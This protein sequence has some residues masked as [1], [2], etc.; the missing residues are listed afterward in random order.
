MAGGVLLPKL[1]YAIFLSLIFLP[2]VDEKILTRGL[3]L[4]CSMLQQDLKWLGCEF[5][6]H[7]GTI[8][9]DSTDI[10][11]SLACASKTHFQHDLRCMIRA[12]LLQDLAGK[13]PRWSGVEQADV[14]KTTA[15]VRKMEPTQFGRTAL[16]RD[17]SNAHATPHHL[18]RQGILSTPAC[19]YCS[20][21]DAD[22]HHIISTC[23]RFFFLRQEWPEIMRGFETWPPCSQHC[24][25]ASAALPSSVLQ[26]WAD[27]QLQV[28]KLLETWMSFQRN[29]QEVHQ[30]T[31]ESHV[32]DCALQFNAA[33]GACRLEQDACDLA[34]EKRVRIK[35]CKP[36]SSTSALEWGGQEKDYHVM[37]SFWSQWTPEAF[38]GKE[39]FTTWMEVFLV[40]LEI[41]GKQASFIAK[42]DTVGKALWKFR[43]LSTKLLQQ[44]WDEDI[45]FYDIPWDVGADI[46]WYRR[47][48]SV[49]PF[50]RQLGLPFKRDLR[51]ICAQLASKQTTLAAERN[52]AFG[53]H[54]HSTQDLLELVPTRDS[55]TYFAK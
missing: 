10:V 3:S 40:F 2:T 46:P 29:P 23:P 44:A 37:F 53:Y 43:N 55:G 39:P 30:I 50:P 4:F 7:D 12:K 41:G 6:P 27:I 48:P 25:I 20:C 8:K 38:T 9:Q 24:L 34:P 13:H 51:S 1:T 15:L 16:M 19:P 49:K 32:I 45:D 35:W 26:K 52:L 14:P 54:I 22:V 21:E 28:A 47:L 5:D 31:T 18:W 33:V 11:T 42:C 17:L 36:S